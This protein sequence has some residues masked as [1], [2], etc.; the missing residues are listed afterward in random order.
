MSEWSDERSP[1][2]THWL[3]WWGPVIAYAAVI[4][5]LS[6]ISH[7]PA[8][9]GPV[10]DKWAHS[11]AYSGLGLVML[12]AIV[13]G[14]WHATAWGHALAAV[15]LATAYG[16]TDEFHQRFVPG[17]TAD[18]RDLAAD[19]SGAFAAVLVVYAMARVRAGWSER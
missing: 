17:R 7:L 15:L 12:R 4:F 18:L 1:R 2:A 14:R 11:T 6:S 9:P 5:V 19:A 3:W 10:T 8:L 16:A 13:R